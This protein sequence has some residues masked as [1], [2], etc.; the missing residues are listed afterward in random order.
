MLEARM[1][2]SSRHFKY[3]IVSILGVGLVVPFSALAL[4]VYFTTSTSTPSTEGTAAVS[5][6]SSGVDASPVAQAT[7]SPDVGEAVLFQNTKPMKIGDTLVEASVARTW[8]ERIKGL[9]GTP[10]LPGGVVK[11]FVFETPGYHSIWMKDMNY[12]IDILWVDEALK[13]VHIAEHVSPDSFPETFTPKLPA[14]YVIETVAG[15]VD[16]HGIRL[17]ALVELPIIDSY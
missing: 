3:S 4:Y 1:K 2:K 12:A 17:G 15:F 7:T 9:S 11:L 6:A 8:P 14:V 10:A 5:V 16:Q 13:I